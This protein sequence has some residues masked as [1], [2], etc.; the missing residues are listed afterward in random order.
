[1]AARPDLAGDRP[2]RRP[3]V[4]DLMQVPVLYLC[5]NQSP[6][7]SDPQQQQATGGEAARL[8]RPRRVPLRRGLLRRRGVRPRLPPTDGAGRSPTSRNT[9]SSCSTRRTRSGT[10]K[11]RWPPKQLRPLL[12][13]EFGCRT[14]VVYAPPDPPRDPRPS[15]SCLWELS[16]SGREQQF[17]PRGAGADRRRPG[18]RHQ[19]P[20]LRHQPR[21][22]G[23]QENFAAPAAPQARRPHRAGK[24][25]RSPSFTIP[26]A[27]TRRRGRWST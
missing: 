22:E 11:R 5:G 4:D 8:P 10:P 27:A 7:P 13:I 18:H 21:G 25:L 2:G 15:L 19:H 6:L 23:K 12:G 20:G 16:R 24:N 17:T 9:G 1:M 26:A 14:S 3:S